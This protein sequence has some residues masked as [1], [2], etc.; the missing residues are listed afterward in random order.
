MTERERQWERIRAF[1]DAIKGVPNRAQLDRAEALW[2]RRQ[3]KE[4]WME[5]A[6]TSTR[7][8]LQ[9]IAEILAA[10]VA[11]RVGRPFAGAEGPTEILTVTFQPP[12]EGQDETAYVATVLMPVAAALAGALEP[13]TA[14]VPLPDVIGAAGCAQATVDGLALRVTES[15][16]WDE[17][18]DPTPGRVELRA[19]TG[20]SGRA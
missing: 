9:E 8:H 11:A 18:I 14:S 7:P 19:D 16:Q 2:A 1:L 10:R 5:R 17:R 13:W 15:R 12:A 3:E 6:M 4:G 20:V